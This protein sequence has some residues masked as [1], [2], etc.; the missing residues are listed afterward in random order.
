M[1]PLTLKQIIY[2][3][4]TLA[5]SHHQ[6]NHF[7]I[8]DF[9]E[10]LANGD[11]SYPAC[12]VELKP[13]GRISKTEKMTYYN[14]TFHFF[15]LIDI[16]TDSNNNEFEVKSDLSSIAQDYMAMLNFSD[17]QNDW[18]ISMD[19]NFDI[20]KYK[21]QDMAAGVSL[22]VQIATAYGSNR[23]QVPAENITFESPT[24][25]SGVPLWYDAKYIANTVYVC[26]GTEGYTVT[27]T[28][29]KNRGLL[30]VFQGDKLLDPT[31][32]TFDDT[33]G[34]I[35]FDYELQPDQVLQILN[36]NIV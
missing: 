20:S 32:F 4:Q 36:R 11:V 16:A 1:I 28:A 5:Q 14:F 6:I 24:D 7:F 27:I 9:D 12:F 22:D 13:T 35:T 23:C 33:T 19:N 15:D 30:S 31:M 34:E 26:T 8:G 25:S 10:F 3:L 2:R 18:F 17:Y 21:L 29:L